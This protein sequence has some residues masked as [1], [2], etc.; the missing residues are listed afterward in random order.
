MLSPRLTQKVQI[1]DWVRVRPRFTLR[2]A[3]LE[4]QCRGE[5]WTRLRGCEAGEAGARPRAV[6]ARL[7]SQVH[8]HYTPTQTQRTVTCHLGLLS[9][10]FTFRWRNYGYA[11][12]SKSTSSLRKTNNVKIELN[13]T[14]DIISWWTESTLSLEKSLLRW[15]CYYY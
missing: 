15:Y 14:L 6:M 1:N 4:P 11:Y 2:T 3:W 5:A 13:V 8:W 7:R 12:S 10:L 9:T